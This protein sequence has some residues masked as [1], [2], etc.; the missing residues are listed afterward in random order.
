MLNIQKVQRAPQNYILSI[1][2]LSKDIRTGESDTKQF[3]CNI[4]EHNLI[5]DM[6][7]RQDIYNKW[8]W[9]SIFLNEQHIRH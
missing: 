4:L 8:R 9:G 5:G 1:K 3:K 2:L 6:F 7:G